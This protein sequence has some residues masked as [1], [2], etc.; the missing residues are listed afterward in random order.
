MATAMDKD[1]ALDK[2]ANLLN[3]I[4]EKM[5][6][7]PVE[8]TFRARLFNGFLHLSLE[9][10][11]SIII[12]IRNGMMGSAA[13]LIRPQYEALTRGL[14][15]QECATDEK[16]ESFVN[17]KDPISLYKM[18]EC[19]EEEFSIENNP[20]SAVYSVLKRRMHDFTH[21]GFNQIS[22]RFTEH[23]LV[24]NFSVEETVQIIR[25]SQILAL[26]SATFA[27]AVAGRDDLALQFVAEVQ[28]L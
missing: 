22:K 16:V 27:T 6:G 13:A 8:G 5:N 25:L 21:G 17:G 23:E 18:V 10:F 20:L 9:H 1:T 3:S 12:L 15:F 19:L 26:H 14:Y 11:G 28:S 7:I 2:A 24:S 4:D